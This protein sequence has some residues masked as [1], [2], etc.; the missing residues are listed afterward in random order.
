MQVEGS[1]KDAARL[2]QDNNQ[3]HQQLIHA[4]E[5]FDAQQS[6]HYQRVKELESEISELS[7]WKHQALKRFEAS[8][9]D[10]QAM[11]ERLQELLNLGVA[12][13]RWKAVSVSVHA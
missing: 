3:L 10:V 9:R 4:A 7:F 13:C 5:K 6:Q 8:E 12:P 11:K 1:Q 2:V